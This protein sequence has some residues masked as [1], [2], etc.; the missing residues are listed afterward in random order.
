MFKNFLF[1][2]P[3]IIETDQKSLI[4]LFRAVQEERAARKKLP[5]VRFSSRIRLYYQTYYSWLKN[6]LADAMSRT[7][8]LKPQ[9]DKRLR[10]QRPGPAGTGEGRA[11][12]FVPQHMRMEALA[13]AMGADGE[14]RHYKMR[15]MRIGCTSA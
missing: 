6:S 10:E 7:P 8:F 1:G 12:Y 13:Y 3:F 9:D 15:A 4:W 14:R 11:N 5:M 2:R